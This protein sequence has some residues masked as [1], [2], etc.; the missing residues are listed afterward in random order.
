MLEKL[1]NEIRGGGTLQPAA[2]ARKLNISVGM[3][4]MMLEDLER[5]GMLAQVNTGC[6]EPCGGCPLVGEC[7]VTNPQGRMW[8]L[9]RQQ[10]S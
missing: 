6:S 5:R 3:V 4:E 10:N 7:A 2:L 8:M 1:L 9:T